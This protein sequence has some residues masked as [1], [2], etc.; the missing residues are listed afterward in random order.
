MTTLLK[1]HTTFRLGGPCRELRTVRSPDDAIRILERWT[2]TGRPWLPLGGGSNLLVDDE[3]LPGH[4]ILHLAPSPLP[5]A[6]PEHPDGGGNSTGRPASH[7]FW[8]GTSL[9]ALAA[10]ACAAGLSGLEDFSGIPGTLGGAACG[11][12]GAFGHSLSDVVAAVELWTPARG[13]HTL[14]AAALGYAYRSSALQRP[15]LFPCAVLRVH[16]ALVPSPGGP[17]PLLARRAEILALRAA[18]HPDT[19]QVG[20]AGSY[21]KNLPPA[22]PGGRRQPAGAL[23]DAI[24]AKSMRVG[25]AYVFPKHANILVTDPATAT[26]ADVHALADRLSSAVLARFGISLVPEVRPWPPAPTKG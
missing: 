24:G 17:A 18:K 2:S 25:G 15:P 20:T 4:S 7:P 22:E 21:F 9:D 12:A 5:L 8:A 10:A 14:H 16:L 19:A 23:L 26:A 3:G 13:L 6:F 11:N 1:D